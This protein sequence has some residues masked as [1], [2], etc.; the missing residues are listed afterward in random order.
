MV[1]AN[2][3]GLLIDTR[4]PTL[5]RACYVPFY[6]QKSEATPSA[7]NVCP[8]SHSAHEQGACFMLYSQPRAAGWIILYS[9]RACKCRV[10]CLTNGVIDELTVVSATLAN[11]AHV[12]TQ[13]N[14]TYGRR[15]LS[16]YTSLHTAACYLPLSSVYRQNLRDRNK[17]YLPFGAS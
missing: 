11:T 7:V 14:S 17:R 16:A 5:P 3:N 8:S 10:S 4:K 12:T 13:A 9:G 15:L 2:D 1:N 6:R